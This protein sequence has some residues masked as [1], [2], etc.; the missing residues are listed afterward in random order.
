VSIG[1]DITKPQRAARAGHSCCLP[2]EATGEGLRVEE[3]VAGGAFLI[4]VECQ[5]PLEILR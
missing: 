4:A 2:L 3:S 1:S 5:T